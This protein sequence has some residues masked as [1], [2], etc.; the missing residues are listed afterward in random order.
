MTVEVGAHDLERCLMTQTE[1]I[2]ERI[3]T[4]FSSVVMPLDFTSFGW[5]ALPVAER[6]S[7]DLALPLHLVHVDTASPWRDGATELVLQGTPY[8]RPATIS[9]VPDQYVGAGLARFS[10]E[11]PPLVVMSAHARTGVGEMLTPTSLNEILHAFDTPVVTVGPEFAATNAELT[12]IVVCLDAT[13]PPDD[14]GSDIAAWAY[15]LDLPVD[16][17]TVIEHSARPDYDQPCPHQAPVHDMVRSLQSYGVDAYPVILYGSRPGHDI[18]DY[19]DQVPGT[20]VALTTR[21]RGPAVRAVLGSVGLK[22]VR[23]CHNPVLLRR[24]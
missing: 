17:L 16:V 1:A 10:A 6:L 14:F 18:T 12:R 11:Q 22:V 8:R 23:H 7:S 20:L 9:V 5:R 21:A 4:T 13:S 24:R 3:R 19:V 15:E 2:P